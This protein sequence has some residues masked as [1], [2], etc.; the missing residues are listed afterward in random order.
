[1]F[2]SLNVD[3][4]KLRLVLLM[5]DVRDEWNRKESEHTYIFHEFSPAFHSI[6]PAYQITRESNVILSSWK[7]KNEK[8][9][10]HFYLLLFGR[11]VVVLFSAY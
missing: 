11:E 10:N 4:V 6:S 3:F 8:S 9:T 2:V 7:K 5:L 1:M